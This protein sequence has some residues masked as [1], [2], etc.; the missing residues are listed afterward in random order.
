MQS[1]TPEVAGANEIINTDGAYSEV[2]TIEPIVAVTVDID[3]VRIRSLN[4]YR[5]NNG[6]ALSA[7]EEVVSENPYGRVKGACG[8]SV[9]MKSM[10]MAKFK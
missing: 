8:V 6:F 2:E 1:E 4:R 5:C 9:L 7:I 10:A 3:K